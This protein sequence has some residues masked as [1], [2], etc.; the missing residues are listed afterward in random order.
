MNFSEIEAFL[1]IVNT[2]SISAAAEV[3]YLSQSAVSHRLRSLEEELDFQLIERQKGSRSVTLTPEGK[4]FIPIAR[5]MMAAWLDTRE[6]K[7]SRSVSIFNVAINLS[8]DRSTFAPYRRY[9]ME[10]KHP[11]RIQ[12]TRYSTPKMVDALKS[13]KADVGFTFHLNVIQD[14]D[15]LTEKIFSQ[16]MVVACPAQSPLAGKEVT[17]A[18]LDPKCEIL[19]DWGAAFQ[20]WHDNYWNSGDTS[21]QPVWGETVFTDYYFV[22]NPN[23]WFFLPERYVQSLGPDVPAATCRLTPPPPRRPCYLLTY[24]YPAPDRVPMIQQFCKG[25]KESIHRMGWDKEG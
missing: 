5:R 16:K 18:D 12:N 6:I 1:T 17:P 20:R 13:G 7:N 10:E 8:L 9:L 25:L 23:N 11:F 22:E 19:V 21:D 15:I 4:R 24:R 2:H 3:L 14:E